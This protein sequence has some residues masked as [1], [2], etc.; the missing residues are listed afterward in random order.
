MMNQ[1]GMTL[2]ELLIVLAVASLVLV[3]TAA[4]SLPWME[5]ETMRSAVYDV[6]TYVQLARIE[7]VTRNRPC[8]FAVNPTT[9]VIAVL[10]TMGTPGNIADDEILY[11]TT[12]PSGVA[13]ARPT[14]GDAVTL[15][16]VGG[17]DWY[18]TQ[19]S[20][21]GLVDAGTGQVHLYGGERYGRVSVYLAGGVQ[22][23]RWNGSSWEAGS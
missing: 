10:D 18:G 12:M 22:V 23:E 16:Q 20:S 5:R 13:F 8:R 4:Y 2:T 15:Q 3:A 19:F 7:A 14:T 21:D 17:T 11:R 1:K 6:Q 9:G